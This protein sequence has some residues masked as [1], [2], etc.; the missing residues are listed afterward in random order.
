M[1][2]IPSLPDDPV[3]GVRNERPA[4]DYGRCCWCGLC[5]D[6]CPTGSIALSRE[7]MHTCREDELD[8]Y[9]VLPDPNGVHGVPFEKGWAKTSDADLVD[10]RAA[11]HAQHRQYRAHRFV[12][13]DRRRGSTNNGRSWKRR[14][15]SSAVCATTPA[16]PT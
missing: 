6:I 11:A 8:S 14:A 10:L 1:V 15:A 16:P 4:I 3:K 13:R 9:F 12:R 5:V 2:R 7:Y